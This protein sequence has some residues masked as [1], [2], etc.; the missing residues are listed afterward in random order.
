MIEHKYQSLAQ[1]TSSTKTSAEK[2]LN[3]CMGLIGEAGEVVDL[4]K[5]L[6]F[7]GMPLD[8]FTERLKG[9]IGDVLW[10]CA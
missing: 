1:R 9:E 6:T 5:K 7:Q 4:A 3:G 10:Y 2:V 8:K